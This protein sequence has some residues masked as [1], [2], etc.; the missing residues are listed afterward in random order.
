[1]IKNGDVNQIATSLSQSKVIDNKT[2]DNVIHL[3]DYYDNAK[4]HK[5]DIENMIKTKSFDL[6]A[7]YDA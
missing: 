1:M 6:E 5:N 7:A 3:S 2:A 4:V